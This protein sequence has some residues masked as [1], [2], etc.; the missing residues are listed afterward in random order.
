[1]ADN[2]NANVLLPFDC[3]SVFKE[4]CV[5]IHRKW[6]LQTKSVHTVPAGGVACMG[7]HPHMAYGS[8]HSRGGMDVCQGVPRV[9]LVDALNCCIFTLGQA[10]LVNN[11][12]N[13]SSVRPRFDLFDSCFDD[14]VT[15]TRACA[16]TFTPGNTTSM[17]GVPTVPSHHHRIWGALCTGVMVVLC[18]LCP[19]PV[20]FPHSA[21]LQAP[22]ETFGKNLLCRCLTKPRAKS[23]SSRSIIRSL[24]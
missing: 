13:A 23:D 17:L 16:H 14:A 6:V 3:T 10:V 4:T 11:S 21:G 12:P 22:Q 24:S 9:V 18:A 1:M 8:V 7:T 20:H 2:P 5:T 15:G 19:P